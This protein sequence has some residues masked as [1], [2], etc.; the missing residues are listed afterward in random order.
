M[1]PFGLVQ[2]GIEVRRAQPA[3]T[4]PFYMMVVFLRPTSLLHSFRFVSV[5]VLYRRIVNLCRSCV[6]LGWLAQETIEFILVRASEE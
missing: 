2:L 1:P 4:P 5:G 6:E 3:Y